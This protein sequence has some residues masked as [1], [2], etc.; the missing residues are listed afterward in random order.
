ML[1]IGYLSHMPGSRPSAGGELVVLGGQVVFAV[2]VK[3]AGG[4]IQGA[5]DLHPRVVP[6]LLDGLNDDFNRSFVV[7]AGAKPP[8][9]PTAVGNPR[10]LSSFFRAWKTS[11]PQRRAS[12]KDFTPTGITMN[13]CR[14]TV[15]H[16][17]RR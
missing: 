1:T 3:L 13:S 4:G 17:R 11:A 10:F 8:S 5:G 16:A 2:L 12:R 7:G 9:S 14:S 6:R 15:G